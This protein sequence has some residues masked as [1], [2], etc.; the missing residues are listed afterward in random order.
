MHDTAPVASIML[1]MNV[2]VVHPA[3]SVHSVPELIPAAK[4]NPDAMTVASAG[5]GSPSHV[6]RELVRS[7]TRARMLHVPYPGAAP[8]LT[9][10]RGQHQQVDFSTHADAMDH[11]TAVRLRRP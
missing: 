8:A 1:A 9:H 4:A 5:V 2:L 6:F 3:S 10:L 11:I 7:L